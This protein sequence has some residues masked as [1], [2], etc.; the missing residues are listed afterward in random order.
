MEHAFMDLGDSVAIG[1]PN[2]Y[3]VP[4]WRFSLHLGLR[5]ADR[6]KSRSNRCQEVPAM[7]PGMKTLM[8]TI[9]KSLLLVLI[10]LNVVVLLGQ[11]WPEGAPPF[12]RTV[13]IAF[14][15][16]SLLYFLWQLRR[17]KKA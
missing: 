13:N 2:P 14:L 9:T 10:V 15:V 3:R 4:I 5:F 17:A 11:I 16:A 6:H 1:S 7:K 8:K 12:A